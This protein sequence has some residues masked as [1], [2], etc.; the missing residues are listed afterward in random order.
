MLVLGW[1]KFAVSI[2]MGSYKLFFHLASKDK[3]ALK[4]QKET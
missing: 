2:P 3:Q 4:S 1:N